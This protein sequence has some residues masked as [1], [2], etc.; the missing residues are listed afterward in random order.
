MIALV[1]GAARQKT[2]NEI[3]L[4]ILLVGLTIVFL[5][6]CVTLVPL[7]IYS[8]VHLT[9]T[10]I[11]ALLVCLIPTT[12]GGLLSA[13]GIAG[14]DRL[15][16]KNVIAMSGRA[17]EAAG[18]VD[19]LLLDK[20]GTITLGNRHGLRAVPG[21]GRAHR[22]ARRGGDAVEPCRRD[23]RGPI[24]RHA[25][26]GQVRDPTARGARRRRSSSSPRRPG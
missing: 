26:Q 2:P 5:L 4:H 17:V 25:R 20:T 21:R 1:E 6:A 24:D 22:G 15:M 12:I 9:A 16:R 23:A 13:I 10:V 7:G 3:A 18:D 11:V 14:M 19:V 8:G